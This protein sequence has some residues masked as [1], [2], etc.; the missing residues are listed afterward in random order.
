[1]N[2]ATD[3]LRAA[4]DRAAAIRPEEGGFPYLAE[5][6]RQAGVTHCRMTVPSNTML[7]L[8]DAGAVAVQSEPLVAGMVDVTPFDRPALLAALRADQAGD[9]TFPEFVQGCWKAGV[10]RYDVDLDARR[11]VYYGADGDSYTETYPAVEI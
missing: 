5:A 7:Y 1:M 6:L 10:V 3:R 9:S 2:T 8:T 4:L 11:C